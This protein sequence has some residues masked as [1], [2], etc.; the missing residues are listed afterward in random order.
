[1]LDVLGPRR[2]AT[3]QRRDLQDFVDR[4]LSTGI[5]PSTIRNAL[6]P[7]RVIFR[8]AQQC[9]DVLVNPTSGLVMPGVRGPAAP[10]C[11]TAR[12]G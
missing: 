3:V 1:V 5:D 7:L 11:A 4:L 8:R 9:G 10:G 6:M 2:L 12:G